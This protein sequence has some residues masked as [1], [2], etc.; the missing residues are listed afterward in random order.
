VIQQQ[1]AGVSAARNVGIEHAKGDYIWF[2]DSDD[3]IALNALSWLKSIS[4]K[5]HLDR[6]V[7][8]F[9][10]F[11]EQFSEEEKESYNNSSLEGVH[12]YKDANVYT[13]IIKRDIIEKYGVRFAAS[14]YG[15]D[16][17]FVFEMLTHVEHQFVSEKTLYYYRTRSESA[18]AARSS[19][20]DRK[21]YESG[22]V[23]LRVLK[24]YLDGNRGT[25][26]NKEHC[27]NL[28]MS[29]LWS[30]IWLVSMMPK[31]REKTELASLKK[32]DLFP[33]KRPRECTL[34]K[35][36]MFSKYGLRGRI[37][38]FFYIRQASY[39][40][41]FAMRTINWMRNSVIK[42]HLGK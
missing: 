26:P 32:E 27:A 3:V 40:G 7:F 21:R 8:N 31:E 10:Q 36:Y 16:C 42:R 28:F 38:D 39:L 13:S 33:R 9:Y 30:V 41:Y 35:S 2:V 1:N 17:L 29:S 14:S 20:A 22:R 4:D 12:R 18:T 11:G 5:D 34:D 37:L 24:D 23:N 25:I 15:E 6:I 19:E